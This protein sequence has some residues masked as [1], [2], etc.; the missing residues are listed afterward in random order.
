M[1]HVDRR[2]TVG[3]RPNV[4]VPVRPVHVLLHEA[5]RFRSKF[6]TLAVPEGE[7]EERPVVP[8]LAEEVG[9]HVL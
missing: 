6:H 4:A 9:L 1:A 7:H 2:A 8:F 5:V 3:V